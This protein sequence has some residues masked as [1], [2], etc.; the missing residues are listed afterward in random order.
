MWSGQDGQSG[1]IAKLPNIASLLKLYRFT[2]F[3]QELDAIVL[4]QV[5]DTR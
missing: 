1:A 3:C 4:A 5:G 2:A